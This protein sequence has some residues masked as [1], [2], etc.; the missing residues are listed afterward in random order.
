MTAVE[1]TRRAINAQSSRE[2]RVTFVGAVRGELLKLVT[3]RAV[4]ITLLATVPLGILFA[5]LG[6][7]NLTPGTDSFENAAGLA[8]MQGGFFL[9][10]SLILGI[11][12]VLSIAAEHSSGQIGSTL[13]VLP[14]RW[15]VVASK[16]VALGGVAWLLGFVTALGSG[17]VLLDAAGE[18]PGDALGLIALTS[19][20]AGLAWAA[21][22]IIALSIG[23]ILRSAAFGI[24]ST[25][26]LYFIVPLVLSMPELQVFL[27]YL[28][29]W[30]GS[31]A[32]SSPVVDVSLHG[33]AV[34]TGWVLVSVVGWGVLLRRRDV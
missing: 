2:H 24:A 30:A 14:R 25:F 23:G 29:S 27:P 18:L 26:A 20:R 15:T 21:V 11:A 33:A 4:L 5:F 19:A 12:S 8:Q 31:G 6:K 13:S 7:G 9:F 10:G 34:L 28:P 1:I 16:G 22:A 32:I 3:V 17:L